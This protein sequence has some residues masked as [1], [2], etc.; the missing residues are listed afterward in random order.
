MYLKV[1][2]APFESY[3]NYVHCF[4][5]E[6]HVA[7][8]GLL[9]NRMWKSLGTHAWREDIII[10]NAWRRPK[11]DKQK[12]EKYCF[13]YWIFS[14]NYV[15]IGPT[16]FPF[17]AHLVHRH[18]MLHQCAVYIVMSAQTTIR[19]FYYIVSSSFFKFFFFLLSWLSNTQDI[20]IT[21]ARS[22]RVAAVAALCVSFSRKDANCK[23]ALLPVYNKYNIYIY[24][25]IRI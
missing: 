6:R 21:N 13:F 5:Q 16:Y 24:S 12:T 18:L 15:C 1:I 3:V 14:T 8:V 25:Q 9:S 2:W 17:H 19:Q 20:H 23:I 22:T 10:I 11:W 4:I 7:I